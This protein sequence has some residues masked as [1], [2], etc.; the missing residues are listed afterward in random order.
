MGEFFNS[1]RGIEPDIKA[2][3]LPVTPLRFRI[4]EA[5][6]FFVRQLISGQIKGVESYKVGKQN[7]NLTI[8]PND[9][10]INDKLLEA[11][12]AFYCQRSR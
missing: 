7:F 5:A 9:L 10:Q 4:N 1:G 12:R 11:F 8:Q 2:T 3:S 6:F